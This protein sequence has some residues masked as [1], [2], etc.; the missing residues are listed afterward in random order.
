MLEKIQRKRPAGVVIDAVGTLIEAH[1]SV[2][3]AYR[4]AALRQGIYLASDT[5]RSRFGRAFQT[6]EAE[7]L[8]GSL[9]TDERIE[10]SRWR[11]IVAETLPELPDPERGFQE[12]W[13][14][15]GRPEAWR[16]YDDAPA[17]LRDLES[18]GIAMRIG[19]NFDGRLRPIVDGLPDLRRWRDALVISSEVGYRKPHP[20]FYEAAC[21]SLGMERSSV[22]FV[23]DDLEND[24]QGPRRAG[25]AALLLD[26]RDRFHDPLDRIASLNELADWIQRWSL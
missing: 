7:D 11:R 17:V 25:I 6:V 3:D 9:A 4:S 16:P 23:G 18:L 12:L 19:S 2:A 22:L 26:R 20:A 15:F 5:I 21:R 13:D 10:V 14:H 8:G 1:P 24:Y